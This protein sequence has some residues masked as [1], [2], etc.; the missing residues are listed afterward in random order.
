MSERRNF[1]KQMLGLGCGSLTLTP[2]LSSVTNL[3]A[4]NALAMNNS[5]LL[6]TGNSPYK[7]LVCIMLAGGNDSYNML[8]P[9]G[10]S[11]YNEYA[12][13]RDSLAI[14]KEHLIA[15]NPTNT[16]AEFGIH[17]SLNHI[18]SMFNTGKASFV[19]NVGPL[20]ERI[21]NTAQLENLSLPIGL[22][23]HIDQALHW[24][25]SLPNSRTD[26]GWGGRLI[27]LLSSSTETPYAT[28]IS[29]DGNNTFQRG[30]K[31]YGYTVDRNLDYGSKGISEG[32]NGKDF[33]KR[34]STINS[35]VDE[36]YVNILEKSYMNT[37]SN[38]VANSDNFNQTIR[39]ISDS[40]QE[41]I[42]NSQFNSNSE[43]A[44][45]LKM[46]A[47]TIAARDQLGICRQTFYV[48][49]SGYD[50]H[51]D[52]L[53]KHEGLMAELDDALRAFDFA[54]NG[55]GVH[56]DIATF[57]I[58]DFARG[59]TS[60]GDGTDH[61]WG[62]HALVMGGGM[63]GGKILGEYPN[64][65]DPNLRIDGG[66]FIPTTSCDEYFADLAIWLGAS[67]SDLYDV[68]P[69]IGRFWTPSGTVG[70]LGLFE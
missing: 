28:Q 19:A 27:D 3:K 5:S 22:Y 63:Q 46:V 66:R 53:N 58:S 37:L 43:I 21:Q 61:A 29:L 2:F 35:L 40:D 12:S 4:I 18:Q 57:T 9:R 60:N 48:V 42:T 26:L 59:L 8:V 17:P 52:M 69:N 50:T 6:M 62:G 44:K 41:I 45:Q 36:N 67:P 7:A 20:V 49:Q 54:L 30:F 23:S 24:Q 47:K 56:D 51:D 34:I 10:K 32:S 11:T 38:S 14:Q 16:S 33:L 15:I 39:A 65:S 55:L 1:L 68:L 70:P 64:L 25:T 13:Q 31:H